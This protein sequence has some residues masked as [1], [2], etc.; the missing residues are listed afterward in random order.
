VLFE[1]SIIFLRSAVLAILAMV[2]SKSPQKSWV[3]HALASARVPAA[4]FGEYRSL[5]TQEGGTGSATPI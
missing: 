4:G 3:A 1:V 2:L 5:M